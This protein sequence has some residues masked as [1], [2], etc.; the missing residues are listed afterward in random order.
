[1]PPIVPIPSESTWK[2]NVL[3]IFFPSR[4]SDVLSCG[5]FFLPITALYVLDI[6]LVCHLARLIAHSQWCEKLAIFSSDSS[7]VL[8][9]GF[10]DVMVF[11]FRLNQSHISDF[12]E[13][14]G[15]VCPSCLVSAKCRLVFFYI[16]FC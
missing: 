5:H 7:P 12:S 14:M 16:S 3:P 4:T 2:M 8:L 11:L 13:A 15:N 10:Y 9:L 1:M 6:V